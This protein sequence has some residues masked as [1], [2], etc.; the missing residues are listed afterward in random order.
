MAVGQGKEKSKRMISPPLDGVRSRREMHTTENPKSSH[1]RSQNAMKLFC[2]GEEG[3]R[4]PF[5][6]RAP[7]MG[8]SLC[9]ETQPGIALVSQLNKLFVASPSPILFPELLKGLNSGM[10]FK[11]DGPAR[12]LRGT[13]REQSLSGP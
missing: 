6:L 2:L 13:A 5:N 7:P 12:P 10:A 9:G 4:N 3:E 11:R 1:S 8:L